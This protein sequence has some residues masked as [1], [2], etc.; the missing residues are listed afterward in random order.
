MVR[1]LFWLATTRPMHELSLMESLGRRVLEV[2]EQEGAE[3]VVAI[4]LRIG[5][6]SGVDPEALRFAAVVVL[7]GTRAAGAPL[8]IEAIP[9]AFWCAP[10]AAEFEAGDGNCLCPR[11]GTLSRQL[12]RGRELSL[13]AVDLLP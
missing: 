12:L 10:C 1:A 2:A 7:A 5:S 9:A 11:C 3:R 6:L 4:R 8:T 13:V